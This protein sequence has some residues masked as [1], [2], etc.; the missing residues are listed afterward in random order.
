MGRLQP[1]WACNPPSLLCEME[2]QPKAL[3]TEALPES[4]LEEIFYHVDG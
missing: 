4:L 2:R 3:S 1:G